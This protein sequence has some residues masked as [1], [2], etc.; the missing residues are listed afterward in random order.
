MK[1]RVIALFLAATMAFGLTACGGGGNDTADNAQTNGGG[2]ENGEDGT[3]EPSQSPVDG[4][5]L[6][7]QVALTRK[8]SIRR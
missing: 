5:V 2:S 1:K 7:V 3:N 6:S 8:R 4:K